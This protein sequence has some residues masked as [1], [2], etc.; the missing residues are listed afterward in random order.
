M[1]V[2]ALSSIELSAEERLYAERQEKTLAE[3]K[4]QL[5]KAFEHEERL[6]ELTTKQAELN[7]SLDLDKNERQVVAETPEAEE[8]I[9][10][11]STFL[12]RVTARSSADAS[13]CP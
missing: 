8:V 4:T 5:G 13:M 7:A 11:P 6:K 10:V 2:C 1:T 3:Y 12:A 9:A